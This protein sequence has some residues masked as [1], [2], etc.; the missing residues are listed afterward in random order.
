MDIYTFI[1]VTAIVVFTI[2]G[3][4]FLTQKY[5]EFAT[6]AVEQANKRAERAYQEFLRKEKEECEKCLAEFYK[7]EN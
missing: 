5:L 2:A 1:G 4:I 3:I 6:Y 7:G